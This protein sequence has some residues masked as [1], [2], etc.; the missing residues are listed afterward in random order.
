M[1]AFTSLINTNHVESDLAIFLEIVSALN[2][3]VIK[4]G[5]SPMSR[6][7]YLPHWVCTPAQE[8]A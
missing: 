1:V 7:L 8:K 4:R 3:R 5:R 2:Y 6:S